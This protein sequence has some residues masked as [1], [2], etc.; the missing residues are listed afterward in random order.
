MIKA[1]TLR[2]RMIV[3]FCSA[4]G[5]LLIASYLGFFYFLARQSGSDLERQFLETAGPILTEITANPGSQN[6]NALNLKDQYFEVLDT[7]GRVVQASKNLEGRALDL[8]VTSF[9]IRQ[10][11]FL[12]IPNR[13]GR[14]LRAALFPYRVGND[15]FI[16]VLSVP[17]REVKEVLEIF[18]QL[19]AFFLPLSLLLTVVLSTWYVKRSLAPITALT[20][21]ARRMTEVMKSEKREDWT[22]LPVD[23]PDD[24]LGHLAETFNQL[25]SQIDIALRQL[26]QFVTDASH[27]LRTPLSV[28]RGETELMLSEPRTSSEYEKT[29]QVIDAEL[30]KLTR[31]VEGLFTISM[32]DAGQLQVLREPVYL[33]EILEE[34]CSI[35]TSRAQSKNIQIVRDFDRDIAYKG[36]EAFLRQLF[37]VF[38]DNSVKYSPH[39]TSVHVYIEKEG[40]LV[41][42]KF[43]DRGIGIS[44][45]DITLIFER[46][47][48]AVPRSVGETQSGGLGLA[49]AKAIVNAHGGWIDCQSV[50]GRGSTFTVN[51]PFDDSE[52]PRLVA[53]SEIDEERINS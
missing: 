51:L 17:N 1:H 35:A 22:A 16:L 52:V 29:L 40:S 21:H 37:L 7:K 45:E 32:A 39:E 18:G 53:P 46:F 12:I 42:V 31:I 24:E 19:M 23:R 8:A 48:R 5:V 25:F 20:I 4:V 47:Y 26:R 2:F 9:D 49:I 38:L 44:I 3:H 11:A 43:E 10:P 50:V 41:R 14:A 30:R 33:N 36:D 15:A 28:L 34:A 6:V 13:D 27:E